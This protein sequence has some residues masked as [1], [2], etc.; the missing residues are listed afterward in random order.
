MR[1][2][3]LRTRPVHGGADLAAAF[4]ALAAAY[5]EAHGA[6]DRLLAYRVGLLLGA[7]EL[8]PTDRLL[9]LGCGPGHHLLAMG[10]AFG[11]A[12]GVDFSPAMVQE[13]RRRAAGRP[14][15]R[16]EVADAQV[17]EAIHDRSFDAVMCVGA[18]EHMPDKAAVFHQVGRVLVP[19]GRFACLTLNGGSLWYRH[20]APRLEV[21]TRHFATDRFLDD[22]QIEALL[23]EAGLRLERM[24]RWTFVPRGDVHPAVGAALSA[25]DGLGRLTGMRSLRG[26]LLFR[27]GKAAGSEARAAG[28]K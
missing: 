27:A 3:T 4:D 12:V 14:G 22:R 26:G 10:D 21:D 20:L 23:D 18:L 7:L 5:R 8:H 2:G 19:G 24:A 16:F 15:L 13:A 17:L 6:A 28:R 9:D 11:E 25:L 1:L